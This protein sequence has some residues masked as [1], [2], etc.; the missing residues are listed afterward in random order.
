MRTHRGIEYKPIEWRT[1]NNQ[2][3]KGYQCSDER[4]LDGLLTTSFQT[5][6]EDEMMREID[7]YI[8]NRD[9]LLANKELADKANE[10]TYKKLN[11]KLD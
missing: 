1:W 4:L 9:E 2:L 10:Y 11:Y 3:C 6:S 7:N 5:F 8:D